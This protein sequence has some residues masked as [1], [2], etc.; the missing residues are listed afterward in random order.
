M[1]LQDKAYFIMVDDVFNV[2]MDSVFKYFIDYFCINVHKGQWS[3]SLLFVGSICG[4]CIR[5]TVT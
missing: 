2:F 1:H 3:V 4:L 5:V